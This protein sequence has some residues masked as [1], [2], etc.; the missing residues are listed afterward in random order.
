M[1][2]RVTRAD[3][4]QSLIRERPSC[5]VPSSTV[6]SVSAGSPKPLLVLSSSQSVVQEL[7]QAFSGQQLAFRP[8]FVSELLHFFHPVVSVRNTPLR[9]FLHTS[10]RNCLRFF[11]WSHRGPAC[12][13]LESSQELWNPRASTVTVSSIT[14]GHTRP[15]PEVSGTSSTTY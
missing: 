7:A 14:N 11:L 9:R 1:C 8:E 12:F 3:Q 5:P 6:R 15:I 4:H 10:G 2:K 13:D